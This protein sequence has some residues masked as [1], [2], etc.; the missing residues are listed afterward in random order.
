DD[1]STIGGGHCSS[2]DIFNVNDVGRRRG[3]ATIIH[4]DADIDDMLRWIPGMPHGAAGV[5]S[6]VG[7]LGQQLAGGACDV[8][9]RREIATS[10][11]QTRWR[12]L[13][14][15]AEMTTSS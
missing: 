8:E 4:D 6:E 11:R 14:A 10:G 5:G 12:W 3:T 9:R 15:T 13:Q 7:E 1:Q 2:D